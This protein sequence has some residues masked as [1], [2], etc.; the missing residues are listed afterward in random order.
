M[1]TESIMDDENIWVI[2][3][4]VRYGIHPTFKKLKNL[5][6]YGFDPDLS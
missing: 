5:R 3:A 6:Y 2:D 4:G 1:K